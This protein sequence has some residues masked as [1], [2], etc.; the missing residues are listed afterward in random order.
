MPRQLLLRP[1]TLALSTVGCLVLLALHHAAYGDAQDGFMAW[2]LVLALIPLLLA[3]LVVR[4][5]EGRPRR[6]GAALVAAVAW[7][8]FLPNAPYLVTDVIHVQADSAARLAFDLV[9]YGCFGLLGLQLGAAA[10][11]PLHR[12]VERRWGRRP[13]HAFVVVVALLTAVGVYLG[14]VQ[15]WNSWSVLQ[16][17]APLLESVWAGVSDPLAHPVALAG[18]ILFAILF[19]AAYAIALRLGGRGGGRRRPLRRLRPGGGDPGPSTAGV[20]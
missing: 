20:E 4:L 7:L 9:V 14:R 3:R 8:L 13:G 10:L 15:R 5:A 6:S 16:D 17:P 2:N 1:R 18:V 12:L 11:R 19:L